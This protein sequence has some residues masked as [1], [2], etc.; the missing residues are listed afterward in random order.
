MDSKIEKLV[1]KG[2]LIAGVLKRDEEG[3]VTVE[4]VTDLDK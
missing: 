1:K 3:F 2:I 4:R